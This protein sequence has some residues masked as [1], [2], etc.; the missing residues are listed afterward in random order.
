MGK[1]IRFH[2][3]THLLQWALREILGKDVRQTG[4]DINPE[5]MRFDFSFSRKMTSEEIGKVENLVNEKFRKFAGLFQG[6][7]ENGSR[8]NWSVKFFK[9][10]Y[11]DVVKVY[12][13]ARKKKLS[14]RNFVA[15]LTSKILPKSENLK[16]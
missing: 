13:S 3:A 6:N 9:A 8:K 1:V 2:T 16:F 12:L 10:K 7:A 5:R 11:P 4:S 14:V 15:V